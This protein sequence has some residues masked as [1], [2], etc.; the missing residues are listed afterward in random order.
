MPGFVARP[1]STDDLETALCWNMAVPAR[2][3]ANLAAREIDARQRKLM[4]RIAL[5]NRL[6]GARG[7]PLGSTEET[8]IRFVRIGDAEPTYRVAADLMDEGFYANTALFPAVSKG[9]GGLRI[10]LNIHQ[11]PDDIRALVDAIARRL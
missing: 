4:E 8:P 3:R 5:F 7:V 9:N 11:T 6:A 1:L 10:A 2:V